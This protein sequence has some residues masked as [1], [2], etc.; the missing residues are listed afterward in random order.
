[1]GTDGDNKIIVEGRN[2][3]CRDYTKKAVRDAKDN[4]TF[5]ETIEEEQQLTA[6]IFELDST[7]EGKG[8]NKCLETKYISDGRLECTSA[9]GSGTNRKMKVTL[10]GQS[11]APKVL[12]NYDKPVVTGV[13][14]PL[15]NNVPSSRCKSC[16]SPHG[17]YWITI[18]G[19]N[20][21][22]TRT[23]WGLV[24]ADETKHNVN[25]KP[26]VQSENYSDK[27]AIKIGD[28]YCLQTRHIDD[29]KVQ[30]LVP[31]GLGKNHL[32]SVGPVNGL[33]SNPQQDKVR[34]EYERPFID[35]I[36][37][38]NGQTFGNDTV[39]IAG[40]NFGKMLHVQL[41]DYTRN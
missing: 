32:V 19:Y 40:E 29:K 12:F 33:Y 30:C 41:R 22:P 7:H 13:V 26:K 17:Q 28:A 37:P 38:R 34:W 16:G 3:G 4:Y 25:D 8:W 10:G 31:P 15:R 23:S 1:M 27:P 14:N 11:S 39:R 20:F 6:W 2:F 21:G 9:P 18:E 36:V 35:N 5:W 24:N